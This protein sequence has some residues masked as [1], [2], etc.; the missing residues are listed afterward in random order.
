MDRFS[1]LGY[2]VYSAQEYITEYL[3]CVILFD[4]RFYF[5]FWLVFAGMIMTVTFGFEIC[6]EFIRIWCAAQYTGLHVSV[7]SSRMSVTLQSMLHQ[8]SHLSSPLFYWSGAQVFL[9]LWRED[10]ILR[11]ILE[12][13]RLVSHKFACDFWIREPDILREFQLKL[14]ISSFD[15]TRYA[16][17][18][19]RFAYRQFYLHFVML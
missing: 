4:P 13:W 19:V 17:E 18:N 8:T 16:L 11:F 14:P 9:P 12:T 3:T 5:L 10:A 15:K 6:N 7:N 2:R 1:W